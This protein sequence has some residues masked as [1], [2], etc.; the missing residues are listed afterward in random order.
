MIHD[1]SSD[2]KVLAA[3]K[4][5]VK[6]LNCLYAVEELLRE[7]D[8][9]LDEIFR[10]VLRAIPP[11]WQFP[12]ACRAKIVYEGQTWAPQDFVETP[13]AQC[14]PIYVQQRHVGEICVYYTG[15][16]PMA[17]AG[18]FLFDEV[19]LVKTIAERLGN[20]LRQR[21]LERLIGEH[22][23]DEAQQAKRRDAEWRGGLTLVRKTDQNQYERLARKMLN[24]LCWTGVEEALGTV[25]RA[26]HESKGDAPAGDGSDN[27]PLQK[28]SLDREYFL[29]DAPFELAAKHLSDEE[30]LALV[31]RWMFEDRSKFLVKVLESQQ[32]SLSEIADAVRRYQQIL[33]EDAGLSRATL[34]AMKVSLISRFLT[35][36][37]EFIQVAKQ[38]IDVGAFLQLLDRLV[39]PVGSHGKLGGKSAGLFLATQILRRAADAVPGG[40]AIRTPKSWYLASDGLLS[41]M[42]YNDLGDVIQ[43]KYKEI[44]Q[45]RLEYTHL[46]QLYKHARF[47]PE[48]VKGLSMALDDFGERPLIVRSS[49]LLEDR[50]G[51]SFSGKYKSLFLANQGTKQQRLEALM[52]AIAEIYASVF[53]PDP[54]EY[55]RERGLL[56]FKEEMGV[57][58]QEVVGTRCGKYFFPAFSGV[59]FSNNEFRWSPRIKRDDG[60]IRLVPGLG[61]RA[62]D[63]VS[64]DFPVLIAPGQPRLRANVSVDE[65]VRYSPKKIDVINLEKNAFET[66]D[67]NQLLCECG[68][69]YPAFSKVFSVLRDDRLFKPVGL[70]AD[71]AQEEM[72]ATFEGLTA[73]TPFVSQ[74]HEMLKKLQESLGT[75][76]DVEFASDGKEFYLLQCRPQSHAA[77]DV[78]ATIPKDVPKDSIIFTAGRYVSNGYVPEVTHIVYVDPRRYNELSELSELQSVGRAVGKLNKVLPKRQ[79]VLMGPGRWGSRGDIKLGVAVTYSD[80]NNTAVLIEIARRK[81]NYVP[82]LS[83]GTHFFQDLVESSIRYLPLYPDDEG[84][85]FNERFLLSAP[86]ILEDVAPEFAALKDIVRVI[87]VPAAT[88]GQVLRVL[89]NAEQEEALGV[90]AQPGSRAERRTGP[91]PEL[92]VQRSGEDH[93]RWRLQMAERIA[94]E[95]DP[96]RF[97]VIACY[98]FGSTKNASAGPGSD[99]DLLLHARGTDAQREALEHWLDGWSL[100][101][102]EMNYRRCGYRSDRMLDVHIITDDDIARRDSFAS[103]IGAITDA[104]RPLAL[105][106]TAKHPE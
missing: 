37:L 32:S 28:L 99:I 102:A 44:D 27:Y 31:Q 80:I 84:Q 23:R 72:I 62:V 60:L 45:V 51:T 49:S 78:A 22:D 2:D 48:I 66:V 20:F 97:G 89:M 67:L 14:A 29:S 21:R 25:E 105:G 50:L 74:L 42:E 46:V 106:G 93:W 101:L 95:I 24:H 58:I 96:A 79:F 26:D 17:E 12:E 104:A 71:P 59:A 30:I 81:G 1:L 82:E 5:R 54:I 13:W 86:N 43:H 47:P 36:Q 3:L 56:D 34:E 100:C 76:V 92:A 91:E 7:I 65:V 64:D 61:T 68:P 77:D 55:R 75:P 39:F 73:D 10:G 35:E 88:G 90:L 69:Y 15:E 8:K 40:S 98:V 38:Y 11:G 87:D 18:P 83:F 57:L 94:Q 52:D 70:L 4:E 63:R 53:G 16:R 41:F 33:P 9:P 6:E 19:R 85:V 103:K